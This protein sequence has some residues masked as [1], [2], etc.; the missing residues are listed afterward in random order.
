MGSAR[1]A[2]AEGR[3]VTPAVRSLQPGE[4]AH[5]LLIAPH[6]S[7]RT[8]PFIA[9]APRL[10]AKVLV[11]SEG[12]HSLVSAYAEGIHVDLGDAEGALATILRV[13]RRTPFAGVIGTDDATIELAARVACQLGLPHNPPAAVRNARR[14]D[15]ARARLAAAGIAVPGYRLLDLRRSLAAQIE[16]ISFPCVVKPL[17]LSASRGVIRAD[18]GPGLLRVSTVSCTRYRTST[19]GAMCW[20]RTSSPASRWP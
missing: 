4:R 5:V 10:G 8:A 9:A 14:K 1:S 17:A 20:W 3:S 6:G 11:A 12:R 7:Y 15:V 19:N 18:D 2:A 13:A 16:G